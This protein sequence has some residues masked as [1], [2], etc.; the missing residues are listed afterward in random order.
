[1]HQAAPG[2]SGNPRQ[3]M[4][5]DINSGHQHAGVANRRNFLR[6]A[7][8]SIAFLVFAVLS[9]AAGAGAMPFVITRVT[10]F[11][12]Q[13]LPLA[14]FHTFALAWISAA[15]MG[16][17][18][19]Y[20]P[21]LA[22]RPIRF[23]RL[24]T[25]Q[26]V[27]FMIASTGMIVHFVLGVWYATWMAAV[28]LVLSLIMFAA[29]IMPCLWPSLGR[30]LAETGMFLALCFFIVAGSAGTLLG[31]DKDFSFL[32][33][34]LMANLSGHAHLATL[35]WV[36]IS[37]CA[38]SYRLMPAFLLPTRK[39]PATAIWQLYALAAA[40]VLLAFRLF[41]APQW[42]PLLA[43]SVV[44][45]LAWYLGLMGR[46]IWSRR[47]PL[48]WSMWHV[49]AAM[50]WLAVTA[51]LGF[52]L[53][54]IG[55]GSETGSRI[56]S[57]YGLIAL[58]GWASNYIIGVSYRLFPGFASGSRTDA[59]RPAMTAAELSVGGT[60]APVF[61][62]FNLGIVVAAVGLC[63]GSLAAAQI[64]S[65]FIAMSAIAYAAATLWTLRHAYP[66]LAPRRVP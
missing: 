30:G 32:G 37:I 55:G 7:R 20:A 4:Q 57:A 17:M 64:G 58:L 12:Y 33:G 14:L 40:T 45:T 11:F 26:A 25:T 36:T 19:R 18:Y 52:V 5:A 65:A 23:P 2:T 13:P 8:L 27:L 10:E 16:V 6:A 24:A 43:I 34:S 28:V 35:G 49:I 63:S 66:R 48:D 51:V 31:I 61:L 56:A 50:I 44:L 9:F 21:A 46:L 15:I 29:N 1:M 22:H 38:V 39:V 54:R 53:S 62:G 42:T 47:M 3:A 41:F 59:A 60:R